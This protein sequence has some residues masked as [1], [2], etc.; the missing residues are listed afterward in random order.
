MERIQRMNLDGT[1]KP[2]TGANI[3]NRDAILH[4]NP[5]LESIEARLRID[6]KKLY[7]LMRNEL[8]YAWRSHDLYI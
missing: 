1:N 3:V 7:K 6:H 5:C 2:P 4:A 8:A